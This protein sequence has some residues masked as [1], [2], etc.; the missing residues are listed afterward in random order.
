[1]ELN[2]GARPEE[3]AKLEAALGIALPDN[4]RTFYSLANG[5]PDYRMDNKTLVSFWSIDRILTE[6]GA[7]RSNKTKFADFLIFSHCYMYKTSP[8]G[9]L[10][11]AC[12]CQGIPELTFRDFIDRY[13]K[14][15]ELLGCL[16][17]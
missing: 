11:I 5:M 8:A 15:P 10:M 17:G 6:R 16:S 4:V 12:D 2:P 13:L 1:M 9:T 3:I 7:N 14:D